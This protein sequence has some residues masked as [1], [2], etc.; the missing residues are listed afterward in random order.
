MDNLPS[1]YSEDNV[2]ASYKVLAYSALIALIKVL[3]FFKSTRGTGGPDTHGNFSEIC[4]LK[5]DF[6]LLT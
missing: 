6:C 4:V 1:T 5:S 2:K 3:Y